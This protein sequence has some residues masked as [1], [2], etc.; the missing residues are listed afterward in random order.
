MIVY[1]LKARRVA[2]GWEMLNVDNPIARMVDVP[3]L[4][5]FNIGDHVC[6][7]I[8]SITATPVSVV[9]GIE[10]DPS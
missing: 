6:G 5:A 1:L 4:Y 3:E 8:V 10:E 9:I 2:A 7:T